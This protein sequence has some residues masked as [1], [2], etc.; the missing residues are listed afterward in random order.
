MS[1]DALGRTNILG[2]LSS[3]ESQL[4]MHLMPSRSV[5]LKTVSSKTVSSRIVPF[6][7]AAVMLFCAPPVRGAVPGDDSSLAP[8]GYEAI[9]SLPNYPV[10]NVE[11]Y[12]AKGDGKTD[13]TVAI[14]NAIAAAVA[15]EQGGIV[16]FPAG[17]YAVCPQPGDRPEGWFRPIFRLAGYNKLV[18]LGAGSGRS[19]LSGHCAGLT[20]PVKNWHVNGDGYFK[21]SRF[22]MFQLAG[23]GGPTTGIQFRSL[24]LD[25]NLPYTGNS[26][27]GGDPKTG[28]GW[29]MSHK[30]ILCD[31]PGTID[32]ILI[33]NCTIRNWHGE[34][35]YCGGTT[36]KH[37]YHIN[38]ALLGCNA[39]ACSCSANY[40]AVGVAVGGPR[41]K[42]DVYNGFENYAVLASQQNTIKNC[43]IGCSSQAPHGH[44]L[45]L[46]GNAG[47][48]ATIVGN[49][50]INNSLGI[51]F[52]DTD[53]N[54][55]IEKN[56]FT[57]N[58][59]SMMTSV[60][61]LYKPNPTGFSN[62]TIAHNTFNSSNPGS[63]AFLN[64]GQAMN[65]GFVMS[66]N[67]LNGAG[68]LLGNSFPARQNGSFIV[69]DNT[70][71]D[72]TQDVSLNVKPQAIP[73]WTH[74]TRWGSA[75]RLP[76]SAGVLV[77][78]FTP[79]TTTPII[80]WTDLTWLNSNTTPAATPHFATLDPSVK[81]LYPAG[82]TT[83]FA[84]SKS[85][86]WVLR[87]DPTWNA[88]KSP[89]LVT[90]GL[91]ISVN[92]H[93]LFEIASGL[94]AS[95]SFAASGRLEVQSL[96]ENGAAHQPLAAFSVAIQD[97]SGNTVTTNNDVVWIELIATNSSNGFQE[98]VPFAS[99]SLAFARAVK[100]V[101]TFSGL[102]PTQ[103]GS[104]EL[105]ARDGALWVNKDITI[106]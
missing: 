71:N 12:G 105:L 66:H 56:T 35:V 92:R 82:F 106:K 4:E 38:G 9:C 2:E 49:K 80:P 47:T 83:T 69:S 89:L 76:G 3:V 16:F 99:G 6:L 55:I 97:A 26:A 32:G 14:R 63:F 70:L 90:P 48:S 87:P 37:V 67:T 91:T 64:Q 33:F 53:R 85:L 95:S 93:G 17:T 104:F 30:A 20:D 54:V 23:A 58:T 74:T 27:V 13:D 24:V 65:D 73:L 8:A 88:W 100:G 31:G 81:G 77:N 78:D 39:S 44:G 72:S 18:F 36:I 68:R 79:A 22:G 42:D 60:L 62:F 15:G 59:Q 21:I 86:N 102:T 1:R 25:G 5:S 45:V 57:G 46:I 7:A 28:D 94:D 34:E 50:F 61:G 41:P 103:S 84:L 11:A 101:A 43:T 98:R 96:P 40:T 29:D 75:E 51:L 10:F 52:Q 19:I